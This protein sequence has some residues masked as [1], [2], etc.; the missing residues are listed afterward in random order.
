MVYYPINIGVRMPEIPRSK[1]SETSADTDRS[2]EQLVMDLRMALGE[3]P[4]AEDVEVLF[5]T[6]LESKEQNQG[7][8][9]YKPGGAWGA[10]GDKGEY[11]IDGA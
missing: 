7:Y 6:A 3:I 2:D 5:T 10:P 11:F 4:T 1:I 9:W 8:G